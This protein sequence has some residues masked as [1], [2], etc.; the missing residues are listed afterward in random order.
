[1]AEL[2]AH[3]GAVVEVA[4]IQQRRQAPPEAAAVH[5][6]VL[7]AA[8]GLQVGH[9]HHPGQ[10][11]GDPPAGGRD[12]LL[13]VSA[14]VADGGAGE[15]DGEAQEPAAQP[16]VD[17]L[18]G[19]PL[20]RGELDDEVVGGG[21]RRQ[22]RRRSGQVDDRFLR[23]GEVPGG[24][25]RRR[26][27]ARGSRPA[28]AG[29]PGPTKPGKTPPPP[30]PLVRGSTASSTLTMRTDSPGDAHDSRTAGQRRMGK[31]RLGL[32]PRHREHPGGEPVAA[33]N[34]TART[35]CTRRVSPGSAPLRPLA[36]C[37]TA[38]GLPRHGSLSGRCRTDPRGRAGAAITPGRG[39]ARGGSFSPGAEGW[40]G[41]R[42]P[43][44]DPA[45]GGQA[46]EQ[47]GLASVERRESI[48]SNSPC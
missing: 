25:H 36:R 35:W 45:G 30:G 22:R 41:K 32:G 16:V 4:G 18:P 21:Q 10:P 27:A 20:R 14:G 40:G 31:A 2:A 17:V 11:A 5:E 39:M 46:Q 26:P 24:H 34:R 44:G 6:D 15:A 9:G 28:P 33:P 47:L 3:H 7:E 8:L 48:A 38:S 1:M 13:D 37:S 29:G 43:G 19:R 23:P 12:P 42:G